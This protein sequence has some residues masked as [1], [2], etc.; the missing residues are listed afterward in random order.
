[1]ILCYTVVVHSTYV[2][3]VQVDQASVSA[4]TLLLANHFLI[5]TVVWS[6]PPYEGFQFHS[7]SAKNLSSAEETIIPEPDPD[8]GGDFLGGA[9]IAIMVVRATRSR[10]HTEYV[11]EYEV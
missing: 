4:Q 8:L 10:K 6:L 3:I 9:S 7:H 2:L 1:M 11:S 5:R